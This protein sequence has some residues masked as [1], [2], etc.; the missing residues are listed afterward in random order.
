MVVAAIAL[1]CAA[2]SV[3]PVIRP[4]R[5]L[6]LDIL[7]ALRWEMFGR[8]QDP[9]AS[10]AV[11]VAIDEESLRAAPF[12]DSP[13]LTWTGEIG[14][15]LTA[16]LEGGAKVAGF[17]VVIPSSI[18][19][20]QLP[21][22]EGMLGEKVRGFDRDFLRALAAASANGKVVLGEIL[23]G[24]QPVRPS[25]GQRV[26]V[27][28]QLNIRPLNVHTDHDDIVRRLP[29]SFA[30]N[31][32][33]VPSMAVELASRALGAAPEF[34]ASG[35]MTL[36]GYQVPGRV[37]NTITLNFEGGA[38]DIP[39]FSFADLRACAVKNDKDYFK[40]WFAG[41]VVIFGSVLDIEDRRQ[42]SKRF[43]TGIEGVRTPRC[44][45]ETTP[46][47]AGYRISTIAGVYIHATAVNNL[48]QRNAV[49]EPGPLWRFL[50]SALFASLAAIAA[51]R[52]RPLSAA[53]AW[54]AV[55]MSS[56]AGAT[57]AFNQ[58][59]ALPITEPFLASLF[60]LAA[61][62]GFRFVVA[63]KDRRL[64]QKSFALYLAPHV[65]NRMLSSNKLPE[66]GGET[67]NVTVFF[68]DIEGF[69]LIAEKMSPDGLMELMNEYLSAMTDVIESHGGYVDKYIG[70]SVVAVFGAPADDPEHAANAA[71]AAL[72]CCTQLAELNASSPLFQ[73]YRLAQ[74]IGINSGEALVGNFGSRRRFNYSVMS[75][76]VNLASRLEG[77]NKFYGT[78]VI[79]S[80]TTVALAGEAFAWRELDAIR[81]KGRTGALKIYELLALSADLKSSQATLIANYADGLAHWRAR[82]FDRAAE[83]FGR[84]AEIDRPASLFA[85]RA[86]EL[87]QNPPGAD[88]DPIRTLQEK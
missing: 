15:V 55:I 24:N 29:L 67:R 8:R 36:A 33:R 64:L 85:V 51:W 4:I 32:T 65:I 41:K 34:D 62:I 40:R 76:A 88:W 72:D 6:S 37:P 7:T 2:A 60:A 56:V 54:A 86:R 9:A 53:L 66:L 16:T 13:M 47:T 77:A 80:E 79:A 71:R 1:V 83:C 82:E 22:G 74:R 81:V 84:S 58:A 26:A 3:S 35:R 11:V 42:T 27:R 12:K 75:D 5:G 28:Q 31:G 23:G 49:V 45:A 17:D 69:S 52:L 10:P 59:L 14:R 50:I 61:T 44:A 48:I 20:S 46:V 73:G 78:T 30:V 21:F 18:E 87:A 25:P 38:D 68:S 57:I 39:T 63:D 70:D 43:A 19:Q